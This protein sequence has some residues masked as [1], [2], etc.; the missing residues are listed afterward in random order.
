MVWC[1][2]A[3]S[4]VLREK[5]EGEGGAWKRSPTDGPEETKHTKHTKSRVRPGRPG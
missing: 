5:L 3:H 1:S 4:G 2:V